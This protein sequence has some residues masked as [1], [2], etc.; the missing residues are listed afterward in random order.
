MTVQP[1][2]TTLNNYMIVEGQIHKTGP[3]HYATW[4]HSMSLRHRKKLLLLPNSNQ[5]NVILATAKVLCNT[6]IFLSFL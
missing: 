5:C 4:T 2:F 1:G 3:E 6:A